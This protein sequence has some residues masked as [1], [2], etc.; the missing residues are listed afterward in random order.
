MT[1]QYLPTNI[2][3]PRVPR[4]TDADLLLTLD[5]EFV[6]ITANAPQLTLPTAVQIPSRQ[7]YI[8]SILGAGTV[9]G[10]LGQTIDGDASFAFQTA[11]EVLLVKSNGVNWLIAG[12]DTGIKIP[13]RT[14]TSSITTSTAALGNF[15]V[16]RMLTPATTLTISSS[17]ITEGRVFVIRAINASVGSPVT[18]VTE[19]AETIDGGASIVLTTPFDSV[20]LQATGGNLESIE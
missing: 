9:V 12:G 17:D 13:L 15:D 10:I 16:Y 20:M 3:A 4:E 14:V 18:I 5:D 1:D 7:I 6:I 11:N 19:G 8:K 2:N